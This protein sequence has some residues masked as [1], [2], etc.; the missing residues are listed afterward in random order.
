M[1]NK[2]IKDVFNE[3]LAGDTLKNALE[4]AAFLNANDMSC[5]RAT[6]GYWADKIYF[7]AI[8]K[9]KVF[10]IFRLMNMKIIHGM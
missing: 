4:F 2:K 8:I 5:V 6:T 3:V 10:A 9:T 1:S 7:I